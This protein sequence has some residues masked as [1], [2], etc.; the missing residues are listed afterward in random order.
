MKNFIIIFFLFVTSYSQAKTYYFSGVSG[1]D[2]RTSTQAQNP[3][4]PWKTLTKLN[5]FFASVNPGD[6]VLLKRGET[7]YGSINIDNNS[8]TATSPIVIGA[9][10]TGN[11]PVITGLKTLATWASV[12]NGIYESYNSAFD[13]TVNM[14]LLDGDEQQI[15]RYPNTDAPSGGYLYLE[16][17]SGTTSITDNEFTA[18]TN[19]WA[20]A[21]IVVRQKRWILD[22]ATITSHTGTTIKHTPLSSTPYDDYGYFIQDHIKTL[23][24]LGEWCYNPST[25]KLSMYFGSNSPSSYVVQAATITDL[26]YANWGSYIVFDNLVV[27]GA[28]EN[29]FNIYAGSNSSVTNCDIQFSG[30][31]GV[32]VWGNH[33][34]FTFESNSISNSNN[35]GIEL[36]YSDNAVVRNNKITNTS[37]FAGMGLSDNG[38]GIGIH[39]I[40]NGS[41]VE[42]NEVRNTG[43]TAIYYTGDYVTVKNNYVDSFCITKDDGGG[44]YT[45]GGSANITRKG[46]KVTGNI[47]LNGVGAPNG[48]DELDKRAAQGIYLDGNSSGVEVTKNTVSQVN[49]GIYFHNCRQINANNNTFYNNLVQLYMYQQSY[50]SPIRNNTITNNIIF[51]KLPAQPASSLISE[52]NDIAL[53]GRF[54]S[55]YYARPLDDRMVITTN[56]VRNSSQ[57]LQNLDLEAWNKQY[58][59]DSASKNSPKEIAPYK[60]NAL[61]G[62]NKVASAVS[63][64]STTTGIYVSSGS[65]SL[66]TAGLLDGSYLQVSPS[67]RNSYVSTKI[68]ALTAGK[69]YI[70]KYSVRGI[71]DSTMSIGTY[72]KQF[73]SPY[74]VLTPTQYRKVSTTRN[75]YELLFTPTKSETSASVVFKADDQSKY[76]LDNISVYEADADVTDPDDSIRFEYNTSK[77]PKTIT[78]NGSYIDTKNKSYSNSVVLQ[79]F[80]SLILIKSKG[81][82]TVSITSP[83]NNAT[84]TALSDIIINATAADADGT[85]TKVEFYKGTTLLGT[86][87]SSPY[88]F[89]WNN[90][91]EGTYTLTAKAI[92]N[93]SISTTSSPVTISV[94]PLTVAPTVSMTSP[95]DNQIF[96]A[97][98]NIAM[99]VTAADADGTITKVKFYSGT[100][101]LG[102]D[103]T[104]P[105]SCTWANVPAGSYTLTAQATDDDGLVTTSADVNVTVDPQT[106]GRSARSGASSIVTN[107]SYKPQTSELLDFQLSPNPATNFIQ[108]NLELVP[109]SQ[110]ANLSILNLSGGIL[111]SI[112]VVLSNN[113]IMV[114]ISSLPAGMYVMKLSNDKFI[115]TKK[116][117]KVN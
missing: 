73:A 52:A 42:Y 43:Y 98:T 96:I 57:V 116:F 17:H 19:Y 53:F 63:T 88:T 22:R 76:Y 9:F 64:V 55:N 34:D 1:D 109:A 47:I 75:N 60:L 108:I 2:S 37:I 59:E 49:R 79:P 46:R 18:A 27:R 62:A 21:E 70:L 51:S 40:D 29:G 50:L 113:K 115:I 6:S 86:D 39:K 28:N 68:G 13:T 87:V 85:I 91:V 65:I 24:K 35:N 32:K 41:L 94:T 26:V 80:T 20:G 83:V 12:G 56:F 8:G 117:I 82:P 84:F 48:T 45:Y 4:T 71:V 106:S 36:G 66:S 90:V 92:N 99:K 38:N 105:Y 7:F 103:T 23:D 30:I 25:K 5:S 69:N 78:L 3:S 61:V 89:T 11:R 100:R 14:V 93:S 74:T 104:Y 58:K 81:A 67:S 112:P 16:S 102:T 114:D 107:E 95:S 33:P 44:I 101:L 15:G 77:T 97:P 10:G 31:N 72:F 110:K 111:K 54:D